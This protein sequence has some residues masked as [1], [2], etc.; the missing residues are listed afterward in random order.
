MGKVHGAFSVRIQRRSPAPSDDLTGTGPDGERYRTTTTA[1]Q[2]VVD[3]LRPDGSRL[4]VT[5]AADA[6]GRFALTAAQQ[7][8]VALDPEVTLAVR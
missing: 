3:V 6:T 4:T 7:Q 5:L 2:R 1:T 8:A